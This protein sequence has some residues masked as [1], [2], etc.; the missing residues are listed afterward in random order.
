MTKVGA[1]LWPLLPH[2]ILQIAVTKV[3]LEGEKVAPVGKVAKTLAI[4]PGIQGS[5]STWP[6]R[7]GQIEADV[8]M[9]EGWGS[10][11]RALVEEPLV[12]K[13]L[14]CRRLL[15]VA[16]FFRSR[17]TFLLSPLD[18]VPVDHTLEDER[19]LTDV[20][21]WFRALERREA[22]YARYSREAA[23][24]WRETLDAQNCI[25]SEVLLNLLLGQNPAV[26]LLTW[27]NLPDFWSLQ[28]PYSS[29][30]YIFA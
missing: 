23:T 6:A 14:D 12:S 3:L 10:T 30:L 22:R 25:F 15:H 17:P 9:R 27:R 8:M 5:I 7:I 16:D 24:A 4:L 11:F 20:S 29:Y 21:V 2:S 13:L 19:E 18:A 1:A 28:T 26:P